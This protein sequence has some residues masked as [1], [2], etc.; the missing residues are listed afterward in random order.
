MK[1]LSRTAAITKEN[2]KTAFWQLYKQ[3]GHG[4]VTVKEVTALAGYHRGVFYD[5]FAN[6]EEL[7]TE[8]EADLLNE[9]EFISAA[10]DLHTDIPAPLLQQ[11]SGIYEQRSEYMYTLLSPQGDPEFAAHFKRAVKEMLRRKLSLPDTE[12]QRF[13]IAAEFIISGMIGGFSSWYPRRSEMPAEELLPLLYSLQRRD[14]LTVLSQTIPPA[15]PDAEQ[16]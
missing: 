9:L 10:I 14:A 1:P 11:V 5:Y 4:H 6:T 13:D 16:I 15:E 12:S 3:K 2:L 7:L 8:I